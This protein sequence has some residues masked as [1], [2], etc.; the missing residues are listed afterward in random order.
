MTK[1]RDETKR[2]AI[3]DSYQEDSMFTGAVKGSLERFTVLEGFSDETRPYEADSIGDVARKTGKHPVDAML[4]L[5][6]ADRLQTKFNS[7]PLERNFD[8]LRDVLN[9]PYTIPGISDG[10]AHMKFITM[11]AFTTEF[12]IN[13]VRG[14]EI[15]SLEQAHWRL[16]GYSAL[17]AGIRDRGFIREGAPADVL[18]YDFDALSLGPVERLYDFPAGDWRLSQRA[19]GYDLTIVNGEITFEGND[20]TQAIPGRLLRHGAA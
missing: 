18:V 12:M 8:A 14:A 11:S 9:N 7:P 4:D 1:M 17:V 13:L 20:C 2:Q 10:G 19:D 6:L 5:A 3:R 15:M 16:S